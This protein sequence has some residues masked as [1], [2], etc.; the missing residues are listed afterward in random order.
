MLAYRWRQPLHSR[1]IAVT[2]LQRRE[3]AHRAEAS[4]YRAVTEPLQSRYSPPTER[5][6]TSS[7]SKSF[8]CP[9]TLRGFRLEAAGGGGAA[10]GRGAAAARGL[11][12]RGRGGR[13]AADAAALC[14]NVPLPSG[15]RALVGTREVGRPNEAKHSSSESQQQ[16]SARSHA[17]PAAPPKRGAR[18]DKRVASTEVS[19]PASTE[20]S[21]PKVA[22]KAGKL[23][24]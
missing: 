10:R 2:H 16:P 4:R 12:A 9:P 22:P 23:G 3:V 8:S 11:A 6:V 14:P 13:A 17:K 1:Y 20:V 21:R 19:R 24:A 5:G 18:V 15:F 7:S